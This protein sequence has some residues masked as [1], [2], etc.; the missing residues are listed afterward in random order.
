VKKLLL[1]LMLTTTPA[2]AHDQ[3]HP[4]W[5]EWFAKL[6]MPDRTMPCCGMDDA[7]YTDIFEVT[8]N[9]DY[10]AIITDDGPDELQ[11]V[12]GGPKLHRKHIPIGTKFVVPKWKIN[13]VVNS[14][15]PIKQGEPRPFKMDGEG[16]GNPTG[17]G[18]IF[19][20]KYTIE[21]Y[22]AGQMPDEQNNIDGLPLVWCYIPPTG[23]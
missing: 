22:L 10:I 4:E 9:G 16:P 1:L 8:K 15:E 19:I 2:F 17:R 11:S 12:P 14:H 20:S 21:K 23:L 7:Y 18:I 3:F 6:K 13:D 5:N